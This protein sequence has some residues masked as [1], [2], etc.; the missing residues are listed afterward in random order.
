[1]HQSR[2]RSGRAQSVDGLGRAPVLPSQSLCTKLSLA[3][4]GI[5]AEFLHPRPHPEVPA[6]AGLEG[7]LQKA[8]RSLEASSRRLAPHLR[9]R[10]WVGGRRR[11]DVARIPG[12]K[13]NGSVVAGRRAGM[14]R[15]GAPATAGPS[16]GSVPSRWGPS[17]CGARGSCS[18]RAASASALAAVGMAKARTSR[19]RR[20][21]RPSPPPRPDRPAP[22]PGGL[23]AGRLLARTV[24]PNSQGSGIPQVI[25]G[26]PRPRRRLPQGLVSLRVGVGKVLVLFL[27]LL[28]GVGGGARG[29]RC[30]SGR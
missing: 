21:S 15:R 23:R 7:G 5:V 10:V 16:P 25:A 24:F 29:R 9:M 12:P 3:P 18:W 4:R 13:G 20:A 14:K 11:A 17:P 26:P 2:R 28:C 8:P 22:D 1:M 27:G 30:R 19:R 6:S